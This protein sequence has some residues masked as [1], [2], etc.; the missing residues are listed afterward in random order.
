MSNEQLWKLYIQFLKEN[1]PKEM[2]Q[3]YSKYCRFFDDDKKTYQ[4]YWIA[5]KMYG[6]AY[7]QF[8][9]LFH[10]EKR[11]YDGCFS[12]D[13]EK[14]C[15]IQSNHF[16]IKCE[17]FFTP[18]N[19]ATQSWSFRSPI[20][21]YIIENANGIILSKLQQSC[22]YFFIKKSILPCYRIVLGGHRLNFNNGEKCKYEESSVHYPSAIY[23]ASSNKNMLISTSIYANSDDARILSKFINE[24][25]YKCDAKHIE[26]SYQTLREWEFEFLVGHG[27]VETCC[28][29]DVMIFKE[30]DSKIM[31]ADD[32]LA[33]MPKLQY[34]TSDIM[35]LTNE[36]IEKLSHL[37]FQNKIL[38]CNFLN[39]DQI[40][41]TSEAFCAFVIKNASP[42]STFRIRFRSF[43]A[44]PD[45]DD[46]R[47]NINQFFDDKWNLEQQKPKI[48]IL[49]E[50][51]RF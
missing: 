36:V 4:E 35:P 10:F 17:I 11:Y 9:E 26:I 30:P 42:C 19:T 21:K 37:S 7:V 39:V 43:I 45:V 28:V 32:I 13:F 3:I 41:F 40:N 16:E 15:L 5:E 49:Q 33:K 14:K 34:F 23:P 51:P 12:T 47:V 48:I 38:C 18:E 8:G 44:T 29:K 46:F 24:R 27:N 22:K 25:F 31:K 6:P 20:I 50:R 1:N 2:L